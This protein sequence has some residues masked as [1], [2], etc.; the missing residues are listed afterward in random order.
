[1]PYETKRRKV[2][3]AKWDRCVTDVKRKKTVR[4]PY[5]VCTKSMGKESFR[6]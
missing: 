2:H 6:K 4:N 5:A 1:M 3:T